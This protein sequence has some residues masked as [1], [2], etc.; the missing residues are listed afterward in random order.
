[1]PTPQQTSP[2]TASASACFIFYS[3]PGNVDYPWSVAYSLT[4]NYQPTIISNTRGT[5]VAIVAGSGTRTYTN[6]FGATLTTTV[7]IE[8]VGSYYDGFTSDNLLYFGNTLPVDSNGII[9]SL[10]SPVQQPG[11]GP[12][13]TYSTIALAN[14]SN[15]FLESHSSRI[16]PLGTAFVSSVPGFTSV[17]IG[18]SDINTLAPNYATC[19][20][21]ITFTNG[22]RPATEATLFERR[23]GVLLLVLHHGRQHLLRVGQPDAQRQLALRVHC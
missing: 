4:I 9:M 7:T 21:G 20:A 12:T 19:T 11:H 16:D 2:A 3:L 8:P 6:R 17:T 13:V 10:A 23:Q 22:K 1:M 5:A 15:V 14:V 18:A